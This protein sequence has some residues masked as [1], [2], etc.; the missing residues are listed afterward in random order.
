[1]SSLFSVLENVTVGSVIG[2]F[3][4]RDRDNATQS[5]S[6]SCNVPG[7]FAFQVDAGLMTGRIVLQSALDFE[8]TQAYSLVVTLSV[9][10]APCWLA[11]YGPLRMYL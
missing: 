2:T 5:Y 7:V 10:V 3:S 8:T 1:M 4:F 9:I 6:A 11:I